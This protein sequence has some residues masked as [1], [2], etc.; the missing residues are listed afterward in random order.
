MEGTIRRPAW[1]RAKAGMDAAHAEVMALVRELGLNTV[2]AEASCPNRGECWGDKHVTF[3]ILGRV[4]SR[5]CLF[6]DV[7]AGAPEPLDSAEP[8]RV[9]EAVKELGM[10]YAVI[11]SVTRDDLDDRGAGH[12]I[13]TAEEIRG[14]S[15]EVRVELLVPDLGGK[16]ELIRA[17]AFSNAAVVGHNIEM[18]GSLYKKIRPDSDYRRSLDT[19]R[20]VGAAKDDGANIFVK[21]SIMLGMGETAGEVRRTVKDIKDAGADI[22][23]FGQYLSPSERHWPVKKYYTPGEFGDLEAYARG[24]GFGS[25]LAGPMV[26]S[27]YRAEKAYLE[28]AGKFTYNKTRRGKV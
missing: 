3:I 10:R 12:F 19:L 15:P 16:R 25:V 20:G 8:R 23:Y 21:S 28:C 4:C 5:G 14:L 18:P 1:I 13:K 7:A 6:C 26:R 17:V 2:C 24:L 11:T 22:M 9:A 27:S